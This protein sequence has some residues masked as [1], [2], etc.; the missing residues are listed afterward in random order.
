M[1]DKEVRNYQSE[2]RNDDNSRRIEGK[3]ISFNQPSQYIGFTEYIHPEAVSEEFL[4]NQDVFALLNHDQSKVLARCRNGIGNLKLEIRDDGVYYSFDALKTPLGDEVLAYIRSGIIFGSSFAFTVAD[5]GEKWT[6]DLN[7][8]VRRDI[9]AFDGIYD[10][11]CVYEPCYLS[12]SCSC[13]AYDEFK[14]KEQK[15]EAELKSLME[16]IDNM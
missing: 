1:K 11:S 7:G 15:T 12:T 5:D 16:E 14:E 9:Y 8:E 2:V 3:A 6:R 4:R 10:V 13:R